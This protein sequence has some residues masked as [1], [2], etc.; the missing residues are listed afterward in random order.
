[1]MSRLYLL[2]GGRLSTDSGLSWTA[3]ND[4]K[5]VIG[6]VDPPPITCAST[7]YGPSINCSELGWRWGG[8]NSILPLRDGK[9]VLGFGT[10]HNGDLMMGTAA[11]RTIMGTF[12]KDPSDHRPVPTY[13]S[14]RTIF[15]CARAAFENHGERSSE[16]RRVSTFATIPAAGSSAAACSLAPSSHHPSFLVVNRT[17]TNQ[18]PPTNHAGSRLWVCAT[19]NRRRADLRPHNDQPGRPLAQSELHVPQR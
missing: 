19:F 7:A 14:G 18:P 1:M 9:T 6:Q 4:S 17:P 10:I 15:Y 12:A 8:F 3:Y 2:G 11:R 16:S 13:V 5:A